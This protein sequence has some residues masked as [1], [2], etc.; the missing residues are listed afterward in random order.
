[1]PTFRV[2][3]AELE[4][5]DQ[6]GASATRAL[7]YPGPDD[8]YA[9]TKWDEQVNAP[10]AVEALD[11]FFHDRGIRAGDIRQVDDDGAPHPLFGVDYDPSATYIWVEGSKLMEYQGI[12]EAT[13]GMVTCPLCEGAGEVERETAD[14]FLA[15]YEQEENE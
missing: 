3:Y 11:A 6:G 13:P 8:Y 4:P 1:M 10:S 2:Y 12:D 5:K 7:V 9:E 15:E 14:E